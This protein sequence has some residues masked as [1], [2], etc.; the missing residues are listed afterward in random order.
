MSISLL[1]TSENPCSSRLNH[2]F[3]S[4]F[5]INTVGTLFLM[6][7]P[8]RNALLFPIKKCEPKP[9]QNVNELSFVVE[10]IY[11]G[12]KQ[13]PKGN[14][15]FSMKD[16]GALSYLIQRKTYFCATFKRLKLY[17]AKTSLVMR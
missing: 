5:F 16:F 6:V 14:K 17:F 12:N 3:Q 15:M 4:Q 8:C 13:W 7:L 11:N 10:S 9:R 2:L 1:D